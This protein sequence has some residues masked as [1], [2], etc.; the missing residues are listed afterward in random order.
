MHLLVLL[1]SYEWRCK[2]Q[3][4]GGLGWL[5]GI[6]GH[7]QCHH[8]IEC[9]QLF[10]FYRNY[11][12]IL[13]CFQGIPSYLSYRMTPVEFCWVLW[14]QKTSPCAI[15]WFCLCDAMFSHF[16]RTPTCDTHRQAQD[17]SIYRASIASRG[18]KQSHL[19]PNVFLCKKWGGNGNWIM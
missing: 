4:W 13:Y 9:I 16:S 19:S 18:K 10:N 8:S 17:H 11:A 7:G 1:Q 5:G 12:A 3:K 2:M 14:Q 15:M 6:Q